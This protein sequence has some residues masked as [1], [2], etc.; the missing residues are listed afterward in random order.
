MQAL[1]KASLFIGITACL[2]AGFFARYLGPEFRNQAVMRRLRW[3]LFTGAILLTAAGFG[4]VLHTISAFTSSLD[5]SL[6]ADYLI[7]SRQGVSSLIR[8]G[9][10]GV[11][12]FFGLGAGRARFDQLGHLLASLALLAT[13][14][15]NSHTGVVSSVD[16]VSDL[17]HLL[18]ATAWVGAILYLALLPI[19]QGQAEALN[20]ALKRVSGLGLAAVLLLALTGIFATLLHTYGPGALV[21]T[22][23][24]LV[25]T[26]KL[27]LVATILAIAS[28]NRRLVRSGSKRTDT[29]MAWLAAS[30]LTALQQ[31]GPTRGR[32][33]LRRLIQLEATLLIAVLV[34]TGLLTT[35]EPAHDIEG[36]EGHGSISI[37]DIEADFPVHARF[38]TDPES[39]AAQIIIDVQ[40]DG[41]AVAGAEVIIIANSADSAADPAPVT[42]V[43]QRDGSYLASKVAVPAFGDWVLFGGW[44]ISVKVVYPDGSSIVEVVDVEPP[45]E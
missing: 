23:Y 15:W 43:D 2:G 10:T 13:V 25:L 28:V 20:S 40:Q 26:L 42:A 17:V 21:K 27:A 45:T 41:Q 33:I 34:T 8:A 30:P 22:G 16:F 6:F 35:R 7:H 44:V 12:L 14:S 29:T 5:P 32:M 39:G 37:A 24:G 38:G 31:L 18:S 4:D 11:L 19:W 36:H 9:L 1:L 3:G